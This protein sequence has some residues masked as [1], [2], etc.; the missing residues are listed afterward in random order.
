MQFPEELR[1]AAEAYAETF[2]RKTLI[3]AA[4]AV[5]ARYREEK[6]SGEELVSSEAEIAAYSVVRMP[7]TFAAV[8]SALGHALENY[9][10]SISTAADIGS[11]TGTAAWA[12]SGLLSDSIETVHCC[13]RTDSMRKLGERLMREAGFETDVRWQRFA[14]TGDTQPQSSDL[15]T[16][17]Y[18]LNELTDADRERAVLAMWEKTD[19]ML[20]IVEPGTMKGYAN[21]MQARKLLTTN[22]AAIAYP[23]PAIAECPMPQGDWCNMS[24]RAARS[25]LHKQLKGA[26]VPYEDEKFSALAAVR[27]N[28]APCKSRILR[29]PQI[30]S[31]VITLHLCTPEGIIDSKV[32][33]SSKSFKQARKAEW[34]DLLN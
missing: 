14:V 18:M 5:S 3:K 2:D 11:G 29:H 27:S 24:A 7:A 16:A 17:A 9:T 34:G 20:L 23:C 10:G 13:E 33:R 32:T 22:G 28:A 30:A 12:I 31:G 19:G 15:I 1:I 4:E 8:S 25:K 26:D 6:S 21:I